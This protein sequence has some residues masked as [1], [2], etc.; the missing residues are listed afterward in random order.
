MP[1]NYVR[2]NLRDDWEFVVSTDEA[3]LSLYTRPANDGFKADGQGYHGW[4]S[5]LHRHK[6]VDALPNTV[7]N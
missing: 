2:G 4:K 6:S 7:D 3:Y 1:R 5:D